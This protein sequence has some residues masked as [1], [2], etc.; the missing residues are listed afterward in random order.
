MPI[1]LRRR[2]CIPAPA[3]NSSSNVLLLLKNRRGHRGSAN[4]QGVIWGARAQDWAEANEPAWRQVFETV[5]DRIRVGPGREFLDVGCEAGGALAVASERGAIV[6]GLD[7]SEA[8][9]GIAAAAC[10]GRRSRS[11][12][13]SSYPFSIRAPTL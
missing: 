3:L 9:V 7:A 5:M 4:Q 6:T 10:P 11:A 13:W 1:G 2:P 8:L 12:T